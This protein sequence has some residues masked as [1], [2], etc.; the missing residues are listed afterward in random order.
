M[1][2]FKKDSRDRKPGSKSLGSGNSGRTNPLCGKFSRHHQGRCRDGRDVCF[3]CGKLGHRFSDCPKAGQQVKDSISKTPSLKSVLVVREFLY[4]FP[5]D[6]P[7][8]PFEREIDFRIYVL[9]DNLPISIPPY[10]MTPAKLRKLKEQLKDLLDKGFI[11]PSISAWGTP[12]L[13]V[14][15]KD[16]GSDGFVVYDDTSRVGLGCVLMQIGKVIAYGRMMAPFKDLYG[17]RCRS[18]AGWFTACGATLIGTNSVFDAMKK[19]QLIQDRLKIAQRHKKSYE[20][21]RRRDL[22]FVVGL[23][24][25]KYSGVWMVK[26]YGKKEATEDELMKKYQSFKHF[27]VVEDFSNHHYTNLGFQGQPKSCEAGLF[28]LSNLHLLVVMV[29]AA[30]GSCDICGSL[31]NMCGFRVCEAK[32]D[33]LRAVIIESQGTPYHDGL[34]V[35][36]V[37]FP[38]NYPGVPT[39]VYYY[40]GG[41]RL[42]PNLYNYEKVCLGLLNTWSGKGNEKWLPKTSTMLQVLVSIQALILN[43]NPFFDKPGY[44]TSYAGCEGKRR[45]HACHEDAFVLSLKRMTYTLRRPPKVMIVYPGSNFYFIQ[46]FCQK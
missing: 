13:F 4:V 9:P 44:E 37:L 46:I 34:F 6:L 45:S 18:R 8:V 21:M 30:I 41:L 16:D 39:M 38:Q 36:D 5:E 19:V 2:K 17:K 29:N 1:P 7:R 43:A 40:F 12:L 3:G 28:S 33:L 24:F 26:F 27:D 10:R 11:R 14:H 31:K 20:I 32:K 23:F 25:K 35:F 15:K 42:N 22:E